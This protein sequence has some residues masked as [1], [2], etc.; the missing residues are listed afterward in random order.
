MVGRSKV[1]APSFN[2]A[3]RLVF[4]P[5]SLEWLS[6]L[7]HIHELP[8]LAVPLNPL[9]NRRVVSLAALVYGSSAVAFSSIFR[10]C[11]SPP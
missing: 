8:C 9:T 7:L 2:Q 10:H 6:V 11:L 5:D 4:L 3:R 1:I